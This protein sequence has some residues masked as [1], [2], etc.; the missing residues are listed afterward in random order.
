MKILFFY[1]LLNSILTSVIF[2]QETK[3]TKYFPEEQ[4]PQAID[5]L[6][7][8]KNIK[9]NFQDIDSSKMYML[10]KF[11]E[12]L[13]F[14]ANETDY[15][16][17]AK[18][19]EELSAENGP[20]KDFALNRALEIKE[21]EKYLY[22]IEN[23]KKEKKE[24][25]SKI[26]EKD[27]KD[28]S[29]MLSMDA[30]KV[31]DKDSYASQFIKK[32]ENLLFE[33][34]PEYY[35]NLKKYLTNT[36]IGPDSKFYICYPDGK[37][38]ASLP[39]D[40][41]EFYHYDLVKLDCKGKLSFIDKSGNA[42]MGNTHNGSFDFYE[43]I[44]ALKKSYRWGF[45][46][47]SGKEII[48]FIYEEAEKFSGGLAK[49][50]FNGKYGFIDKLGKKKIDFLYDYADNFLCDKT[51]AAINGKYGIIDKKGKEIIPFDYQYA[52]YSCSSGNIRVKENG[53]F[54]YINLNR[55]PITAQ[56]YDELADF[57]G[58]FAKV[59]LNFKYSWINKNGKE[60]TPII[61]DLIYDF[62]D[63]LSRVYRNYKYGFID[64]SGKEIIEVKY[65]D[66][67]D[68]SEG[69]AAVKD[70][71]KWFFID[72]SGKEVFEFKY[73][74]AGSFHNGIARAKLNGK[75]GFINKD[76]KETIKFKYDELNDFKYDYAPAKY[77]GKWGV[78]DRNENII[79]PF[80]YYSIE[81]LNNGIF[82]IGVNSAYYFLS[83]IFGN[84]TN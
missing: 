50:K 17:I 30:V 4:K 21:Y 25:L 69:L 35:E 9:L 6:F 43:N 22:D 54:K 71:Y 19:W 26:I 8:E 40:P 63:E 70:S 79:I 10:K 45:V 31:S 44:A 82:R 39:C 1:A 27:Y 55:Q 33:F 20:Y 58:D 75:W 53:I 7:S 83:D 36:C 77:Q 52:S 2:A 73:E 76:G 67:K 72:K 37:L 38:L 24:K 65:Y 29:A 61:Y 59:K 28:L 66:A 51:A 60:L 80:E 47:K 3:E 11:D 56:K 68:F 64:A 42:I 48:P 41:V 46:N 16:K 18:K 15:S 12:T 81:H 5:N 49:V 84:K 23:Y 13:K 62:S 34:Y 14:E 32:Y 78:I 74:D 57:T